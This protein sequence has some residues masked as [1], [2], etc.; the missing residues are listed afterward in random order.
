MVTISGPN[1]RNLTL[2]FLI[3]VMEERNGEVFH[4]PS[5]TPRRVD[6]RADT[7]RSSHFPAGHGH[8][9]FQP[10][11]S[12]LLKSP[13]Q[14]ELHSMS[15]STSQQHSTSISTTEQQHSTSQPTTEQ[16]QSQVVDIE[17]ISLKLDETEAR[18]SSPRLQAARLSNTSSGESNRNED[19]NRAADSG[20]TVRGS[21]VVS[22]QSD[23]GS[24]VVSR[25]SDRG[26]EVVSRQGDRGGELVS[27]QGNKGSEVVSRQSYRDGEVVSKQGGRNG[28]KK[29]RDT[30]KKSNHSLETDSAMSVEEHFK[31]ESTVALK[32]PTE[33]VKKE[34]KKKQR[35]RKGKPSSML[36]KGRD[37]SIKVYFDNNLNFKRHI[38]N[39]C[40]KIK[41]MV[42]T[43]A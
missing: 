34:A 39:A 23:K 9:Q 22:R 17:S 24:E 27:R 4:T 14:E 30:A 3:G 29:S 20:E 2:Y 43:T 21:E 37:K 42:G 10:A 40:C 32:Q 38:D 6:D 15:Q 31:Q 25:Q 18:R 7:P 41:R 5:T 19:I 35:K 16:Q 1:R 13:Y 36:L 28:K 26:S 33:D 8:P 12:P 11:E